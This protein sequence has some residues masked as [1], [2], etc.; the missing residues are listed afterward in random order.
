MKPS[1]N[2]FN[3]LAISFKISKINS[4]EERLSSWEFIYKLLIINKKTEK[5]EYFASAFQAV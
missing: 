2:Q 4:Q 1:I 3:T 5:I